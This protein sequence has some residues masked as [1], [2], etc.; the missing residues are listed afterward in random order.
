M[1]RYGYGEKYGMYLVCGPKYYVN[2]Y[3]LQHKPLG[4]ARI[5][6][7]NLCTFTETVFAQPR[8][9]GENFFKDYFKSVR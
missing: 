4:F 8:Q 7:D 6:I 2:G 9:K 5:E 1:K 3:S